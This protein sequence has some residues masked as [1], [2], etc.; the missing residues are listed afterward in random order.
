M[1]VCK[2]PCTLYDVDLLGAAGVLA[3]GLAA[4]WLVVAPWQQMWH[5]YQALSTARAAAAA[6]FLKST[7]F[8]A[9]R[10]PKIIAF[11]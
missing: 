6:I 1:I 5:D 3:L 4:W 11:S 2:K 8:H 9:I 10:P 7:F